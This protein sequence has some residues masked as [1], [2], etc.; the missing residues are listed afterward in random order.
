MGPAYARLLDPNAFLGV[1][2]HVVSNALEASPRNWPVIIRARKINGSV[3]LTVEDKGTGMSE[4]FIA[5]ELFRPM[6]SKKK[7]GFG[8]GAYQAREIMR[9]LNGDIEIRSKLGEGTTVH[10]MLPEC[11]PEREMVSA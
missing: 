10:L 4:H 6:K 2:E 11:V 1:L 3:S 8:I 5:D 7:T 9:E